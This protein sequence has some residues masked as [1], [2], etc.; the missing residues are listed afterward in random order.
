VFPDA[1][2]GLVRPEQRREGVPVSAGG[3]GLRLGEDGHIPKTVATLLD[4]SGA[5]ARMIA[6]KVG[7]RGCR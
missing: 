3:V 2:G 5:S 6:D 7:T 4:E 1:K